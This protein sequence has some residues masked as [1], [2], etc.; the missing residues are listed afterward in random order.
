MNLFR[1]VDE[2]NNFLIS[3][4]DYDTLS[5]INSGLKY[6]LSEIESRIVRTE[7]S[8]IETTDKDVIKQLKNEI[9]YLKYAKSKIKTSRQKIYNALNN[10]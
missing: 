7:Q 2:T 6:K 1:S 3:G 9:D 4:M 8:K 10:I 5:L